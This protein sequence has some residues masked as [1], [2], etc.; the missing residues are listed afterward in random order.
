M[1]IISK[2]NALLTGFFG[3]QNQNQTEPSEEIKEMEENE[4][5]APESSPP[6]QYTIEDTFGDEMSL[7]IPVN[8]MPVYHNKRRSSKRFVIGDEG[9]DVEST[10]ETEALLSVPPPE[11]L[12]Q[13]AKLKPGTTLTYVRQFI[14][15]YIKRHFFLFREEIALLN[16]FLQ[17]LYVICAITITSCQRF[18]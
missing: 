10:P 13:S 4:A 5:V 12:Q 6:F 7:N 8:T 1:V 18:V 3:Q 17:S 11:W 16:L 14:S 2:I 15:Y 9:D